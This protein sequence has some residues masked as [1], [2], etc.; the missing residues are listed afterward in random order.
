MALG[1]VCTVLGH[2]VEDHMSWWCMYGIGVRTRRPR[3]LVV[4]VRYWGTD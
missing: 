2:G 4:Y 1:S 3:L